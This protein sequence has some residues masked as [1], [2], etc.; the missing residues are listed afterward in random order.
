MLKLNIN[1]KNKQ[2]NSCEKQVLMLRIVIKVHDQSL[3]D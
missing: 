1:T 2:I 3:T